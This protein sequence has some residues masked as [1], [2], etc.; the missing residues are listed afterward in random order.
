MNVL[1]LFIVT[2]ILAE[3]KWYIVNSSYNCDDHGEIP[4]PIYTAYVLFL[5]LVIIIKVNHV[6]HSF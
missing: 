6:T 3:I 2:I 4:E 1:F 5:L